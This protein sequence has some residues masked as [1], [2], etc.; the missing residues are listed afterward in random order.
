MVCVNRLSRNS[1]TFLKKTPCTKQNNTVAD[2]HDLS[3][4]SSLVAKLMNDRWQY[5][6]FCVKIM[7][8][9]KY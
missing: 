4:V 1:T 2:M 7:N 6:N 3:L 5:L 8:I 9:R